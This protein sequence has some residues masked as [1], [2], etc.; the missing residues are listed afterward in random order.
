MVYRILRVNRLFLYARFRGYGR[1]FFTV[2]NRT[3]LVMVII[4]F[5]CLNSILYL[6][7]ADILMNYDRMEC[8]ID[9]FFYV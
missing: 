7:S 9:Y 1:I 5:Y 6:I 2:W 4:S 8:E 3:V